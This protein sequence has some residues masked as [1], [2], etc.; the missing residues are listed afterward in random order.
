MHNF[1]FTSH[2]LWHLMDA[3]VATVPAACCHLSSRIVCLFKRA[4]FSPLSC[5]KSS[6]DYSQLDGILHT[7]QICI[8]RVLKQWDASIATHAENAAQLNAAWDALAKEATEVMAITSHQHVVLFR[9]SKLPSQKLTI[10]YACCWIQK[11]HYYR[12]R[13]DKWLEFVCG[14][15]EKNRHFEPITSDDVITS[16]HEEW[17]GIKV[18]IDRKAIK[19]KHHITKSETE[20]MSSISDKSWIQFTCKNE[21]K[22]V[23]DQR[24]K[25]QW[26]WWN[27]IPFRWIGLVSCACQQNRIRMPDNP[28][29]QYKA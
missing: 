5:P 10:Y 3:A 26:E 23:K 7:P 29:L 4:F 21:A 13:S 15:K 1:S 24:A 11:L 25:K 18:K 16:I 19:S 22:V 27:G 28:M 17:N 20:G 8:L 2:S 12:H 9:K 14:L 6:P